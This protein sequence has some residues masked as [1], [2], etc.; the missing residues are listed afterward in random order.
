MPL[1]EKGKKVLKSMEKEYGK[2][3][4][5]RIFYASIKSGVITKAERKRK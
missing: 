2:Q 5:K 3:E 4:G 1:T